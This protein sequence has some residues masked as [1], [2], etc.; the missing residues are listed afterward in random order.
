MITKTLDLVELTVAAHAAE[1]ERP[2]SCPV[3]NINR[4]CESMAELTELSNAQFRI[5][6]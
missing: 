2:C 1:S 6:K 5:S 4:M 3:C